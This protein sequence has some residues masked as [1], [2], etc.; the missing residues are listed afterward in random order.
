MS[1]NAQIAANQANA[2]HSTGPTSTDGKA[3]SCL[4]NFRYGFCGAFTVLPSEDQKEFDTL[5]AGLRVEHQPATVTETI[6]VEKMA[7]HH[8]L[9]QRAMRL[10]DSIMASEPAALSE[11]K[12]QKMLTLF[13]RYQT[14]NDRA[15]HKSLNDLLKLRA[16]KRRAQIGFESQTRKQAE[17][18]RR[19]AAENRKQ[20][21][22]GM[23]VLLAEAKADHQLVLNLGLKH[24][25]RM[26]STPENRSAKAA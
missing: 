14:T 18:L 9:A 25:L 11:A 20:D 23:A 10:Q 21:L 24:S 5:L 26:N 7:Q 16:E 19:E 22:H 15:F 12:T 17:E 4:N 13:L 8:W 1:T 3:A 6:L 2:Q